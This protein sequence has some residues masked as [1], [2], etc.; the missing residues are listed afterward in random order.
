VILAAEE[1][2][3]TWSFSDKF[4]VARKLTIATPSTELIDAYLSEI[5]RAYNVHWAPTRPASIGHDG[6]ADGGAKVSLRP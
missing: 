2:I 4:K 3:F 1:L 6:G 5:G